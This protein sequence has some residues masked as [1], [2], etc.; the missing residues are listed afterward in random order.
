MY[1]QARDA[2][3]TL[4]AVESGYRSHGHLHAFSD[5][6]ARND[7]KFFSAITSRLQVIFGEHLSSDALLN[8]GRT[9]R[10]RE[11]V[12]EQGLPDSER[13]IAPPSL[14]RTRYLNR[15]HQ[16]CE[17][18]ET[19]Y[20]RF[21]AAESRLEA[22]EVGEQ[23]TRSLREALLEKVAALRAWLE[24]DWN[25]LRYRA[26]DVTD[27]LKPKLARP[28][29][30]L[31]GLPLETATD[32]DR[33]QVAREV[34]Q[35]AN[36][37]SRTLD[38]YRAALTNI[39]L[40]IVERTE[41]ESPLSLLHTCHQDYLAHSEILA[42]RLNSDKPRSDNPGRGMLDMSDLR[43]STEIDLLLFA[44]RD[45]SLVEAGMSIR[46]A[47]DSVLNLLDISKR[48]LCRM[49]ARQLGLPY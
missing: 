47:C 24:F 23:Q 33:M 44:L 1:P 28:L 3:N 48:V 7:S 15:C 20:G 30:R 43:P 41:L 49:I 26:S 19:I 6:L 37:T 11:Q 31:L 8:R 27:S 45:R 40:S 34:Q 10:E 35:L 38:S 32:K 12:A 5:L 25:A 17:E 18:I 13:V 29:Y 42:T 36:E 46:V 14:P 2:L 9:L 16:L 4:F 21:C 22:L 39:G